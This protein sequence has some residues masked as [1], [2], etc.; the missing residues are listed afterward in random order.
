[1]IVQLNLSSL[2][3]SR[4]YEY[5]FRFVLGGAMTVI[6]GL[7]AARF[8]PVIGGLFLAFP[9]IFPASATLIEKHVRERKEGARLP[10][11]RRGKEPAALDAAGTALGGF[12]LAAF[13]LLIWLLIVPSPAWA[14]VLAAV[15]WRAVAIRAWQVRRGL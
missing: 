1:M 11:A 3:E 10:G 4:W 2:R 12:G 6:A 15:A 5:L 14:L 8:G 9:A 7:I 13:G